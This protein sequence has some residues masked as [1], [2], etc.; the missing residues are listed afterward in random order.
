LDET[1]PR[2]TAS[3]VAQAEEVF[4]TLPPGSITIVD[5]LALGAIP[6]ILEQH[7]AR[8]RIVA[9]MHLP[10]AADIGISAEAAARFAIAERRAL[11]TALLVIVTGSA[12]LS[13]IARYDVAPLRVVVVEPGTEP[14]AVARGSGA[15]R[16]ELLSVGTLNPGKGYEVLLSALTDVASRQ[17][18]LTCV[19][20]LT[21]HPATTARVR[22]I[23]KERRL[24]DQVTL[25]G[26]LEGDELEQH[27]D[28]ADVFVLATLRETYGMAVAEALAHGLPVVS[29]STGAIPALV[30]TQAGLLVSPGDVRGLTTALSRVI[31][32]ADLR[33]HLAEGARRVRSTLPQWDRAVDSVA[34][35]LESIARG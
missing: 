8:L 35:A 3:A 1:F 6:E 10:L 7:R 23:V 24:E 32:D 4:A 21:R 18:H 33:A 19:G 30:G 29:T 17:W 14:A 12:T 31:G 26:E 9:L 13:L 28:R 11:E 15:S 16:I 20:S 22:A 5:S 34:A 27:Y 25:A 2:P